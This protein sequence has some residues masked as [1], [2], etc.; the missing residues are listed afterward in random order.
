MQAE[1]ERVAAEQRA[2]FLRSR[3]PLALDAEAEDAAFQHLLS[4]AI[5]VKNDPHLKIVAQLREAYGHEASLELLHHA[6]VHPGLITSSDMAF[7]LAALADAR[8]RN[9]GLSQTHLSVAV[10]GGT[11]MVLAPL[12]WSPFWPKIARWYALH[13]QDPPEGTP[14]IC[15]AGEQP[16]PAAHIQESLWR[17]GLPLDAHPPIKATP[18]TREA[19]PRIPLI[20]KA[21]RQGTTW[22]H[23]QPNQSQLPGVDRATGAP[24]VV[25]TVPVKK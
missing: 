19:N 3:P 25:I 7:L 24:L 8:E 16:D 13:T 23:I 15:P 5:A 2:V 22:T 10:Q 14:T 17:A 11:A 9:P 20:I 12:E 18:L 6:G 21:K 4:H 1:A